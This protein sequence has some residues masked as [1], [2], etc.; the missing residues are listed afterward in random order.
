MDS[1]AWGMVAGM[2]V[3]GLGQVFGVLIGTWLRGKIK[4]KK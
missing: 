1:F 2:A 4:K 3:V